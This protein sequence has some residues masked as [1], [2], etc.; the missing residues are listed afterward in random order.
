MTYHNSTPFH[1]STGLL[2]QDRKL[3]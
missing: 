1:T 3:S 2:K